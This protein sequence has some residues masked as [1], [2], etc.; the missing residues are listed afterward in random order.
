MAEA[1]WIGIREKVNPAQQ[2]IHSHGK[3]PTGR[4]LQN[5]TIIA[6]SEYDIRAPLRAF[7]EELINEVKF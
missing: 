4:D 7:T 5:G 3:Q 2:R 6:D 1:T